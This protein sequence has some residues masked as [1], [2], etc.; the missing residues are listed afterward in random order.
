MARIAVL[1]LGYV[2]SVSLGCLSNLGHSVIGVDVKEEKIA[3]IKQ[4][5]APNYEYNLD[6]LISKGIKNGKI[7]VTTEID[8][9][10]GS[11]NIIMVCVGTPS[12][13]HG[14]I[15]TTYLENVSKEIANSRSIDENAKKKNRDL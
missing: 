15:D 13:Y 7:E 6:E 10:L 2:G 12:N 14:D 11:S 5:K 4:G 1:G 8:R 9:T 3:Q